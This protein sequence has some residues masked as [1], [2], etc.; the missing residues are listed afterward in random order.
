MTTMGHCLWS[1]GAVFVSLRRSFTLTLRCRRVIAFP[2]LCGQYSIPPVITPFRH[3][4]YGISYVIPTPGQ[5]RNVNIYLW[6]CITGIFIR[7]LSFAGTL[8]TPFF[9]STSFENASLR[10]ATL[11][12]R[13]PLPPPRTAAVTWHYGTLFRC[14]GYLVCACNTHYVRVALVTGLHSLAFPPEV[15]YC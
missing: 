1:P 7:F 10:T 9:I 2:P 5:P 8:S 6:N 4:G 15:S 11:P 3:I 12:V 14:G 13:P